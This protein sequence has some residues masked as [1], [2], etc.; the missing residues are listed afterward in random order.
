MTFHLCKRA[1]I[2]TLALLLCA[3]TAHAQN[4]APDYL[5]EVVIFETLAGR[6][7]AAGGLYYPRIENS[8][9]LGSEAAVAQ[10]FLPV[11]QGLKLGENAAAIAASRR[12]RLLRHLSWR[13]P[14]LS[15]EQAKAIRVGLGSSIP[16]FLSDE[17]SPDDDFFPGSPNPTPNRARA[18]TTNTVNGTITVRLGRF[19]HMDARLAFTDENTNETFRLAQSRKMRSGELHYIDNPRFGL[20]TQITPLDDKAGTATVEESTEEAVVAPE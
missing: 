16:I 8:I 1:I 13:Q 18:I 14:G 11:E 9:R 15:A 7:L 19:L 12:Y 17:L 10:G 4:D 3:G 2:A 5:I 6:D 20:L